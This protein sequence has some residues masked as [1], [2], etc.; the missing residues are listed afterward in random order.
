MP[1]VN[2]ISEFL[3]ALAP[4]DLAEDWDNV[5]LL[6][7]DRE[8]AVDRLMTCLTVTPASANEAID[9]GADLVITHHPLPFRPLKHL[10]TDTTPGRLLLDLIRA[11]IAVYSPHTAFDSAASGINQRLAEGLG[12]DDIQPLLADKNNANIGAGRF[13]R[14]ASSRPLREM[15]E[16]V[17]TFL[18]VE[19]LHAVGSPEQQ[20]SVVAVACGAA[21]Q[22]LSVARANGCNLL[23]TGET[24]F[25]TCLEAEASNIAML[26][27]GH[28]ASERFA[29]E[30]LANE[31]ERNFTDVEVWASEREAD[32]LVWV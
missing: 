6:V 1:T 30:L 25:H 24:N 22:F 32:P 28:F 21:G 2:A 7:G 26:L 18:S 31:L 4:P 17:K 9:R 12:L 27:P 14:L 5:G 16:R 3:D 23:I 13:G 15:I 19:G 8:T 20:V 10:T 29:V 11:D